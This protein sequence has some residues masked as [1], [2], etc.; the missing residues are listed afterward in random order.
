MFIET[1]IL[2]NF[3][4][5]NLNRDDTN[6]PKDCIFGGHRR[7]RISSQC[8]KRAVRQSPL[9]AEL[10]GG[11]IGQRTRRLVAEI[12]QRVTRGDPEEVARVAA[13]ALAGAEFSVEKVKEDKE[14]QGPTTRPRTQVLLFLSPAEIERY[15]AIIE[16]HY[17]E[18]NEQLGKKK[19]KLSKQVKDA[20]R[21]F[22]SKT[23]AAD[24]ALFGRMVAENVA[25][26]IDGATQVAHAIST[27]AVQVETDFFTA[28]D[29]LKGAEED[30]GAGMMGLVEF[31]S[32][33]FYRYS[34]VDFAQ[35]AQ[36]LS[37]DEQQATRVTLAFLKAQVAAIP[38][39]KQTSMAAQN[40]P[41][42]VAI[43]IRRGGMPMSFANAF[44][45]PVRPGQ[46][47]LTE[48]SQERLLGYEGDMKK[49]Y[50]DN[51]EVFSGE[52]HLGGPKSL[53][54]LWTSVEAALSGAEG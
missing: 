16:E 22:G 7:A 48:A 38:S 29:D 51:G 32:A 45:N 14:K 53:P 27:H 35:L 3:A 28:V 36:N 30:A 31:N 46:R 26:N 25:M 37:G 52:A 24:I 6:A 39:G 2:Q 8:L 1:H 42:V 34:L 54:E 11:G 4:P 12:C 17:D 21:A 43:R 44:E 9:F 47:G 40:L 18:I 15:A 20:L 33:C 5:S 19:G 49:M 13:F 23:D 41:H 10:V 50:G